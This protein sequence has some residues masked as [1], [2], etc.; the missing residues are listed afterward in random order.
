MKRVLSLSAAISVLVL[1]SCLQL[2]AHESPVDSVSRTLTFWTE[3][4]RLRMRYE[5]QI[6]ERSALLELHAMDRNRDGIIQDNEKETFMSDKARRLADGLKIAAESVSLKLTPVGPVVLRRGCRQVYEFET[7]LS[8]IPS[9]I[10]RL[11]LSDMNSR[12]R[13]GPFQWTILRPADL[14]TKEK[15][16]EKTVTVRAGSSDGPSSMRGGEDRVALELLH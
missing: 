5:Q 3:G 16:T 1:G 14:P 4:S 10:Y 8:I 15:S 12:V 2:Q 6:S 9:S 7:D 11:V 13:P